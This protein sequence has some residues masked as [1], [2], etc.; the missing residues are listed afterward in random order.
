LGILPAMLETPSSLSLDIPTLAERYTA[1]TLRP[2]DVVEIVLGRVAE[3]GNDGVWITLMPR[4]AL[5]AEARKIERRRA[6]GE[7]LPLYGLPFGVKDNI[8]VAG[9]PTTVACP[10]FAATPSSHAPVVARL[11][12][13]GAICVGKTNLDQ[14]ATGLVGVRS[15]YGIPANP[16]DARYIPGGSSSGSAVAVAAGLVSFSLGTDTA[17]SG[18]VPAAFN[19]IV[20]LKP[21]RGLLS[22]TGVVPACRSLDCVSVFALTVEDATAVA[23]VAR[24]FDDADPFAR[25]DADELRFAPGPRP[26]RFRFGVPGAEA[27][28]FLGDGG[29]AVLYLQALSQLERMGGARVEIDFGPFRRAGALLYD[30]PFVAE[31]LVAAG[32]ILAEDPEALVPPVRAIFEAATRID[33][34]SVFEAQH[35]LEGLRRRTAAELAGVDF[36]IVPTTPTIY[37]IEEVAAEPRKLNALLGA[38]TNF[39][40][41][42]DLSAIAVPAGFRDTGLPAGVTLLGPAG[43][44]ARLAAFA[45][46]LHRATSRTLGATNHVLA[47]A[48]AGPPPTPPG[49]LLIAVVG[50]HLSGEPLN[51][52]LVDAGATFVRAA[53]TA[54][55]YRLHVVPGATPPKPGLVRTSG[56]GAAIEVEVW[57]LQP[58][59]FGRF[60]AQIPAPLA[61]G[62]LELDDGAS[63]SGFLCESYAVAGAPD[64]SAFGGWRAYL[65]YA[66]RTQP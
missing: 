62:R 65:G 43:H 39:A 37:R 45:A 27:L 26:P 21:T 59:G 32:R 51:H 29:A 63:V 35:K 5:I 30:G 60:V 15:P 23:D 1:G 31:R 20:G 57:A 64:I 52:Q 19:N 10:P 36:L 34:R 7:A 56:E 13:A 41:L 40:N 4:D 12:A 18:R 17:G 9:L 38:F 6:A 54:P 55:R 24:G 11:L 61:I 47:D 48:P 42:L 3:R 50:A 49:T 25:P 8:D 33:G 14:F 22:T 66:R 58:A 16:F 28:D 44:D 46:P 53:R 2:V